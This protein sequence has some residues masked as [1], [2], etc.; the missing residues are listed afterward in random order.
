[1]HSKLTGFHR[2]GF[3]C[4]LL[5]SVLWVS[6]AVAASKPEAAPPL[7]ASNGIYLSVPK[8]AL[9]KPY[10]ISSS[11]IPQAGAATSTGLRGRIVHFEQFADG[12]DMYEST[13]GLLVTNDLPA[14]RLIATFP[15]IE[16]AEG[17]VVID[18]N[19]G[20]RRLIFDEWYG[21]SQQFN[22]GV[23]ERVAE[24]PQARVF[25]IGQEGDQTI[26][27]QS[28]QARN[29][30]WDVSREQRIEVRY[31]IS[32][33]APS[34]FETK[35][36]DV[37]S[38]RY[39]RF[40]ETQ[41]QLELESGRTTVKIVRFDPSEPIVFYYSANTPKHA[42][43][44]VVAGIEYWNNA[45]GKKLVEARK[46]PEGVTAPDATHNIIQWVPWD[47]A[48]FAYA[49]V[50]LDPH[51]GEAYHGQAYMTSVFDVLGRA[52]ARRIIRSMQ[53]IVE[54][55]STEEEPKVGAGLFG[56]QTIC[57]V[58]RREIAAEISKGLQDLL[59]NPKLTDETVR[60]MALDYV[61]EVIAHEVGHILGLRHN[62][63][64]SL[65]A[66]L[67]PAELDQFIE[68]YISN[69]DL[70][71][72][73]D[74]HATS[75]VM[76]YNVF[77]AAVFE[78]WKIRTGKEALAH[79]T[80][81]IRW[82]Y[83]DD[84]Q[85]IEEK[86]LFGTDDDVETFGDVTRF[87]YGRDSIQAAYQEIS[88]VLNLLP[89]NLIEN[90][91]RAR[92]PQD[93]RDRI[94]LERVNL[95]SSRDAELI[96]EEYALLLKWFDASN[97]SLAVEN[98]FDFAGDLN[99][100]ARH[101]AQWEWA[102]SAFKDLGGIGQAAFAY[103]PVDLGI[104]EKEEPIGVTPVAKIEAEKLTEQVTALLE[105]PAYSTF[106][107]LDEQ[108]YT[109]TEEEKKIIQQRAGEF[110]SRF[111]KDIVLQILKT[112]EKSKRDLGFAAEKKVGEDDVIAKLESHIIDLAKEVI[113]KASDDDRIRGKVKAALVEVT[114][115]YYDQETRIAAAKA[116][117][118]DAGSF[119]SWSKEAK[120]DIHK[121]LEEK[122][123]AALNIDQFK[124]FKDS[125]LS[126]PLRE[127]YERNQKILKLL[128]KI[129][130]EEGGE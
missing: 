4:F 113:L 116:L 121:A 75:S 38:E 18:F 126:R 129:E 35:E 104:E 44:A 127:W 108:T 20:M 6:A 85:V 118:N 55:E 3:H 60:Q 15:V 77:K 27:R 7:S 102:Q 73:A 110:F 107:G 50:L 1:M 49:D 37:L 12:V 30:S 54:E 52:R 51:T 17:K 125:M 97:R 23:G 82:G 86:M 57:H 123:N 64:G 90:F 9:G 114:E 36:M 42:V 84:K 61:C 106:I 71:K 100:D 91:I 103:L 76:E 41:P 10:L 48:G 74:K 39:T 45:F 128:P 59:S 65:G 122:L 31:F 46:A 32:P 22:T 33:Y 99:Q 95:S 101:L 109:W 47:N 67:S 66:T 112:Y 8:A 117:N 25:Q 96:A 80:A 98:D 19:Q 115:F 13:T 62:F 40:F 14:R 124:N 68:D 119:D 130:E 72:Y 21:L 58:D 83:F 92:A 93:P 87:D 2:F 88:S 16:E 43:D 120:S 11:Y 56:T 78:G 89:N 63:A 81:A 5:L 69:N 26:I 24:I 70:S 29:R 79:D 94:P 105:T 53:E 34:D 111:E 28:V